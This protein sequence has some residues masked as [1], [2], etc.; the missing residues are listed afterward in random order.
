MA[1]LFTVVAMLAV[2]SGGFC[3]EK[4]VL[5]RAGA[6]FNSRQY[7]SLLTVSNGEKF[8]NWTWPEMCPDK[9]FAVGFSLR[10]ESSQWGTD[11]TALNGIRLICAEDNNRSFLYYIESHTGYF[12]E[13]SN[14][15]Y[16][17]SGRLTSFQIRVE[18]HQGLFG[19]DTAVN[20]IKFR[21]SS[22]PMLEGAGMD[23][24]QYGFWSQECLDGGICGIETKME[25]YQYGLDD[26]SLNDVRFHCC[27]K[28]V[29]QQVLNGF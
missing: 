23:W 29:P 8:G 15:Q 24:G 1:S 16:C 9:F 13:W 2:L 4:T 26:S 3:M 25:E 21:C 14:P 18:P 28:Q 7:K 11:D 5:Q 20:N 19:D 10:V 12:G 22:N 27:A 6:A 17:P